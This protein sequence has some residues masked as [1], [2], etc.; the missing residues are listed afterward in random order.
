[1]FFGTL[2]FLYVW[3]KNVSLS[4]HDRLIGALVLFQYRKS[5]KWEKIWEKISLFYF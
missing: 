5:M 2:F 3:S 4:G 1:M